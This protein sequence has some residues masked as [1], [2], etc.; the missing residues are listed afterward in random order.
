MIEWVFGAAILALFGGAASSR[1]TISRR[2][3]WVAPSAPKRVPFTP[4]SGDRIDELV[5]AIQGLTNAGSY[6]AICDL[7]EIVR[8]AAASHE[9]LRSQRTT[10]QLCL[11]ERQK[12]CLK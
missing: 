4:W 9:G 6:P 7:P 2:K 12:V 1:P 3:S 10:H 8:E 11:S 5:A